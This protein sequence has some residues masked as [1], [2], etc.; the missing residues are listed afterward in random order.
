L[1]TLKQ[2][3]AE[4]AADTTSAIT[5]VTAT[6]TPAA[7]PAAKPKRKRKPKTPEELD[8]LKFK[9]SKDYKDFLVY[10]KHNGTF[11]TLAY[12]LAGVV[13]KPLEVT[14]EGF[15]LF[16]RNAKMFKIKA[17]KA[18]MELSLGS[19]LPEGKVVLH[20]NLDFMDFR[21][22]NLALVSKQEFLTVKE[23][24][25]NMCGALKLVPHP[26]DAFC[27]TVVWQENGRKMTM[28][29]HDI[30]TAK[31]EFRK[32]QLKFAKIMNTYCVFD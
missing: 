26:T 24:N 30:V 17:S 11:M 16:S 28:F 1:N 6:A 7:T 8:F 5:A 21:L 27:Y 15:I 31:R 20:K 2:L 4:E 22:N 10:D 12:T 13:K 25:R 14:V 3:T 29:V 9:E 23:A 18:A 32:L 19:A